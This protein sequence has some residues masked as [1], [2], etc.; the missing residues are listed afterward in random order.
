MLTDHKWL[1]AI[2]LGSSDMG[3][4]HHSSPVLEHRLLTKCCVQGRAHTYWH[5][6][7]RIKEK[8]DRKPQAAWLL[9]AR[10]Q[11]GTQVWCPAYFTKQGRDWIFVQNLQIFKY[12]Q[13]IQNIKKHSEA[14]HAVRHWEWREHPAGKQPC[15]LWRT[16]SGGFRSGQRLV[17]VSLGLSRGNEFLGT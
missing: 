16:D 15:S 12:S 8:K 3:H 9:C 10:C 17:S 7:L 13:K 6:W 14:K 1:V 5:S 4:F 11:E 2:V